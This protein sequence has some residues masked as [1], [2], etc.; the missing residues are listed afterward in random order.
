[1]IKFVLLLAAVGAAFVIEVFVLAESEALRTGNPAALAPAGL[2]GGVADL[3]DGPP[4]DA[5]RRPLPPRF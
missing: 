3:F 1:M 5:A 2:P 4:G